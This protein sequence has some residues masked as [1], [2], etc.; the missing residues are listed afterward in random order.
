M[1][2]IA[3]AALEAT[4]LEELTPADLPDVAAY[5]HQTYGELP[6]LAQ[7]RQWIG[8]LRQECFERRAAAMDPQGQLA[9]WTK[10]M[11]RQF[12]PRVRVH[13]FDYSWPAALGVVRYGE[14]PDHWDRMLGT[15][16]PRFT[17]EDLR[18][19]DRWRREGKPPEGVQ[20][21]TP[22]QEN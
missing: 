10:A 15:E 21:L 14:A 18:R 5:L 16:A 20:Y 1:A 12:G 19:A 9:A 3:P 4:R 8:A 7:Y 17:A 11:T 6:G 22:G 13:G 2:T